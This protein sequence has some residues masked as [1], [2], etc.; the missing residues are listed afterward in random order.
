MKTIV[1]TMNN[2]KVKLLC[3]FIF[4][5]G[6]T[7]TGNA[8]SVQSFNQDVYEV[9]QLGIDG[10]W[11]RN[12][13][14]SAK[15]AAY[16]LSIEIQEAI[17]GRNGYGYSAEQIRQLK[18]YKDQAKALESLIAFFGEC[19]NGYIS[20]VDF[21][22][23]LDRMGGEMAYISRDGDCVDLAVVTLYNFKAGVAINNSAASYKINY[24]W[25]WKNTSG[26]FDGGIPMR[27]VRMIYSNR[28]NKSMGNVS[29]KKQ[30]CTKI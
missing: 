1:L 15:R 23:G 8:Q 10:L 9:T 12:S 14:S 30:S 22:I 11:D 26:S 19:G 25:N 16:N 27:S 2:M 6:C 21:T 13:C 18:I 28:E 7:I 17:D 29:V 4:T 24:R 5:I 20:L 3:L